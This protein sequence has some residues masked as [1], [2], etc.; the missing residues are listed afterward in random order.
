MTELILNL[1]SRGYTVTFEDAAGGGCFCLLRLVATM[2]LINCVI[3]NTPEEALQAA[4]DW[5]ESG[6][7]GNGTAK[8][9]SAQRVKLT[10]TGECGH[11]LWTGFDV[12][13]DKYPFYCYECEDDRRQGRYPWKLA[14][15]I[16]TVEKLESEPAGPVVATRPDRIV[17]PSKF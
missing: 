2:E 8:R 14:S 12:I 11:I 7:A 5:A 13:E 9:P 17:Q 3:G 16:V 4:Y 6:R 10:V 15:E 1:L